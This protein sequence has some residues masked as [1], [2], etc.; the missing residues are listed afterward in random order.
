MGVR[1]RA[2]ALAV[3]AVSLGLTICAQIASA[4]TE[5]SGDLDS[6]VPLVIDPSSDP[7][8]A[9][10]TTQLSQTVLFI[11]S[12]PVTKRIDEVTIGDLAVAGG[13]PDAT[14]YVQIQHH[15][16]GDFTGSPPTSY[17]AI[18]GVDITSTLSKLTWDFSPVTLKKGEGYSFNIFVSG[19][20]AMR[21][22]TWEHNASQVNGG[23]DSCEDG[24][25]DK[26]MW[27]VNGVDD[28]QFE[29]VSSSSPSRRFDSS[30]PGGWLV[31]EQPSSA[32]DITGGSYPINDSSE[33]SCDSGGSR[34]PQTL[35][36]GWAYWRPRPDFPEDYS[37]FI[38]RWGQFA[39]LDAE[40]TDG[41]YYALPWLTERGG[42]P[43]DMYLKLETIDYDAL[44]ED[45]VPTLKFDSDENFFPQEAGAF[46][47]F[48]DP[49]SGGYSLSSAFTN[50][51]FDDD[52]EELAAAGSPGPG[53]GPWPPPMVLG[54][55]GRNYWFGPDPED[56][57]EASSTDY[58]DARGSS[59][60][61]YIADSDSQYSA[62][63]DDVVY[64]RVVYDPDDGRLWLQYWTFYYFNSFN[65]LGIGYH[66]G[67]WEMVQVGL[68]SGY[69]P[70]K[71]TFAAHDQAYKLD[72]EDVEAEGTSPVVYVAA[73][74]HA[75]YPESGETELLG[76]L[77]VDNHYG[78]GVSKSLPL[79][80]INS[81]VRWT[82]W[83][84]RWGSS[85]ASAAAPSP[86]NPSEQGDKW[87]RPS[88]FHAGA[89]DW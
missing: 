45:Y 84:G 27:H 66:E 19:C 41:W 18:D 81:G 63:Y 20:W 42:S 62:G 38:C 59:E 47:D 3:C 5:V 50:I 80:E 4:T 86:V 33:N 82:S 11:Q 64:G 34:N 44:L 79:D 68:S 26:R 69:S 6:N 36:A 89:V 13:C 88:A 10:T 71:V 23:P 78:D 9:L 55:L 17:N 29:C 76:P 7:D 15:P 72:W 8:D 75:A 87:L 85:P 16:D 28:A 56:Q 2:S 30:M 46:T 43:R 22:T 52:G 65:T 53:N 51:L 57:P 1:V 67:D 49:P 25:S 32:W 61:T 12:M 48:A 24:P 77:A 14:A 40:V 58:I 73:R 21:Q 39:P 60:M 31:S 54:T 37:E 74:S 70:E 35:G 83:P